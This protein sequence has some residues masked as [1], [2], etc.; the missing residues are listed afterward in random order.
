MTDAATR[1][2]ERCGDQWVQARAMPHLTSRDPA[3]FWT[4]G[5]WMTEMAGGSDVAESTSTIATPLAAAPQGPC[6]ATHELNGVKW[7]TSAIDSDMA[8]TRARELGP[9]GKPIPGNKGLA[10]FYLET[11]DAA[12][13]P[14]GLRI[15]R[16]KDKL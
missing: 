13:K 16:L 5:Q 2:L 15:L 10:M 12:G 8:L 4:S 11:R 14:N 7:F 1:V 6:G 9:D 3:N